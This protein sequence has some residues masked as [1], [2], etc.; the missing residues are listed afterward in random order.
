MI[1]L[2][3]GSNCHRLHCANKEGK[4]HGMLEIPKT[5][6]YQCKRC[7]RLFGSYKTLQRHN[8]WSCTKIG[9]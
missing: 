8:H 5:F 1:C 2:K 3:I 9:Q 4:K 6:G 7:F